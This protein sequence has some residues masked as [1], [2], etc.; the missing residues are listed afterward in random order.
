MK[1]LFL[2]L[3]TLIM[4]PIFSYATDFTLG[5]GT[6]DCNSVTISAIVPDSN[7][8][9][10]VY[11]RVN[12][13]A[14][15]P[16]RA[17]AIIYWPTLNDSLGA[18]II[19]SSCSLFV[20]YQGGTNDTLEFGIYGI[21]QSWVETEATWNSYSTG[22]T[23][24]TAGADGSGTDRTATIYDL[25]TGSQDTTSTGW[26]A[27][28]IT[29]LAQTW[30]NGAGIYNGTMI[31]VR[32]GMGGYD[33]STFWADEW[34]TT[35][36]RPKIKISYS[37]ANN[38]VLTVVDTNDVSFTV[39]DNYTAGG[40]PDSMI[41]FYDLDS[42]VYDGDT[43][44]HT[45]D[46]TDPEELTATSLSDNMLYYFR[47][48]FYIS[49]SADTSELG[50]ITTLNTPS[51]ELSVVDTN[52]TTFSVRNNYNANDVDTLWLLWD[53]DADTTGSDTAYITTGITQP[54]TLQ[55]TGLT[56]ATEYNYWFMLH[57]QL[58]R[59]LST[60]GTITTWAGD[61]YPPD[62]MTTFTILYLLS[63]GSDSLRATLGTVDSADYTRLIIQYG[64]TI[65]TD[66]N[67][68]TRCVN[69][70]SWEDTTINII[71]D[72]DTSTWAYF[73]VFVLDEQNNVSDKTVDSVYIPAYTGGGSCDVTEL[74]AKVDSLLGAT[75]R[76]GYEYMMAS[77][78][79]G[80][81][82]ITEARL[83][84]MLNANFRVGYAYMM[85]SDTENII[86]NLVN[87]DLTT[88]VDSSAYMF[89]NVMVIAGDSSLWAST[90]NMRDSLQAEG[91]Y[92][93]YLA[94]AQ[95]AFPSGKKVYYPND[96]T[97][98]KDSVVYLDNL[99]VAKMVVRFYHSNNQNVLDTSTTVL[100]E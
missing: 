33:A 41:L 45:S 70:G 97:A 94:L 92:L 93:Y 83:D 13:A 5:G 27:F 78:T 71:F 44:L 88:F 81:F 20:D 21:L 11:L 58:G 90:A 49:T 39:S 56:A 10:D 67:S 68:G 34:S 32:T 28:D 51:H 87:Y 84:S 73:S 91:S 46:I 96:G 4:L 85:A 37:A 60:M 62:S 50:S 98:Y 75:F 69:A 14:N 36:S 63:L 100:P 2:L 65:P 19:V 42:S 55:A 86:S 57:D 47:T 30:D 15:N 43:T 6:E 99:D 40:T 12:A 52:L 26:Y 80:L 61:S 82:T 64:T 1:R 77:D 22:N 18:G 24:N 89:G 23:W 66:T 48:V 17:R 16:G 38:H 59:S 9:V 95:S 7:Y 31:A 72:A 25:H 54:D 3:A 53:T 79:T 35:T 74:T 8:N 29:E 76:V